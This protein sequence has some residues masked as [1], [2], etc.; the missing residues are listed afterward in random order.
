MTGEKPGERQ[1]KAVKWVVALCTV[2]AAGMFLVVMYW[3]ERAGRLGP[4]T[5]LLVGLL[6]ALFLD[7]HEGKIEARRRSDRSKEG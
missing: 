7:L 5:L 6:A 1:T 2:I 4:L 3:P